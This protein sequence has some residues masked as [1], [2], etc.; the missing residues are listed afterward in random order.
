LTNQ[1][2]RFARDAADGRLSRPNYPSPVPKRHAHLRRPR[3]SI[4]DHTAAGH[5][6]TRQAK[7]PHKN[8][9]SSA[10]FHTN[11]KGTPMSKPGSLKAADDVGASFAPILKALGPVRQA[12]AAVK[13]TARRPRVA[14]PGEQTPAGFQR[15]PFTA[16]LED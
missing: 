13:P 12:L 7:V 6:R 11:E 5:E 15:V 9:S 16:V 14:R 8:R 1:Q 2:E 3:H 10:R 4:Q